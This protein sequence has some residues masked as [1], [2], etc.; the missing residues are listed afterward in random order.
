MAQNSPFSFHCM[1][2]FEEFTLEDRYPVVL[3][4]GHTYVCCQCAQRLEK[5]MECRTPLYY[6]APAENNLPS[7]PI[8][9]SRTASGWSNS[10]RHRVGPADHNDTR[11]VKKRLPLPKNVV[12]LSLVEVTALSS[13]HDDWGKYSDS[14]RENPQHK[15]GIGVEEIRNMGSMIDDDDED[16]EEEK[17]KMGT[18][19]AVGVAGTYAVAEKEGLEIYPARPA[20]QEQSVSL[21]DEDID[22]LL[23][24]SDSKDGASGVE[25][26]ARLSYGDRVQ[27]VT[28]DSGW[29]KLARGYGYVKADRQQLVKGE[30]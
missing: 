28:V 27:I 2:C 24:I 11:K 7:S 1:I 22:T 4:C 13:S 6:H 29:A 21:A 20:M 12:L 5:C 3:P 17:I 8:A 14:P 18:S 30:K 26:P 23:R 16:D 10:G 19:L 9:S 25:S 15:V